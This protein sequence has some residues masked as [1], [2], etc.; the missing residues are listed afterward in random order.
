MT[1]Q[2][3][4]EPLYSYKAVHFVADRPAWI[5]RLARSLDHPVIRIL[6][7]G[8][9]DG[10]HTLHLRDRFPT[11]SVYSC[12]LSWQRCQ[13]LREQARSHVF[14]A[15]ATVIPL[16]CNAFDLVVCTSVIE[17]VPDDRALLKEVRRILCTGG[18]LFVRTVIRLPGAVYFR[19]NRQGQMVID[20][21]HVREYRSSEEFLKLVSEFFDVSDVDVY[22][23]RHSVLHFVLRHLMAWGV[24]ERD[25]QLLQRNQ[26][27]RLAS[28]LTIPIPRYREIDV[29]AVKRV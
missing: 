20:V 5:D 23:P 13:R 19:R 12:D 3:E 9:G 7:L 22:Q 24:L 8:A 17:H 26:L 29:I 16:T 28:R 18:L 4:Y 21:T 25:A 1:T 27:V 2:H 15:D 10:A 14:S 6:D 11:S